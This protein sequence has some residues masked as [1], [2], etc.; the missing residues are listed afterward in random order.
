MSD[1]QTKENQTQAEMPK[2]YDHHIVEE[3]LYTWWETNG[4]FRPEKQITLGQAKAGAKP[5]VIAMPPP[6]VTGALHLGHA[7]TSSI[8][9]MLIR[10]HRMLGDPTLWMPGT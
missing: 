2:A 6:N 9:D 5:F 8:E 10:Y 4:Y 3:D 1:A 7:I